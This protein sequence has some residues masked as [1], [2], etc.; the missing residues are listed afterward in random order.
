MTRLRSSDTGEWTATYL[1]EV[2]GPADTRRTVSA[3]GTL[4]PHG[5]RVPTTGSSARF[6]EDGW[7]HWLPDLRLHLDVWSADAELPGLVAITQVDSALP[8]LERVLEAHRPG[9][10]TRLVGCRSSVLT[11]K[12]GLR[13]TVSC[14]LQVAPSPVPPA[15]PRAVVAKVHRV[16]EGRACHDVLEALWASSMRA[17]PTLSIP[18]PVG[19]VDGLGISVQ[20][21]LD[22]KCTL[23]D[24]L[25]DAFS[26]DGDGDAAVAVDAVRDTARGLAALHTSG[27][28]AGPRTTWDHELAALESKRARL[29]T[30]LPWLDELTGTVLTRIG[31]AA[32]LVDPDP[33]GPVHGS[34]RPAQ[35]LLLDGGG[36]GLIDFDKA[37]QGEPA[38]DIAMF[39]VKLRHSA[40]NKTGCDV[41]AGSNAFEDRSSRV[42]A[43]ADAFLAAYREQAPVTDERVRV[44]EALELSSLVL[45]AARKMLPDRAA[46]CAAMLDRHLLAHGVGTG[47]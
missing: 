9:D 19:Y 39:L 32:S 44:W 18:E 37:G 40:V 10:G 14:D 12:A 24:L 4:V 33:S 26:G 46:T 27:V 23:K 25:A 7:S 28:T 29:T 11:Y 15:W 1:L 8:L 22:H 31:R 45:S 3:H 6:G 17:S 5:G 16:E 13:A 42:D 43:L 47:A 2:A 20:T 34:F 21:H 41:A 30:L 38:I 35:V 36:L